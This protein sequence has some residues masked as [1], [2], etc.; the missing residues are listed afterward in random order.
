ML[1]DKTHNKSLHWIFTPLRSL[2]TSDFKRNTANIFF[3][4]CIIYC[5]FD[6][7]PILAVEYMLGIERRYIKMKRKILTFAVLILM[8]WL[9]NS[10]S[11]DNVQG[12]VL[13]QQNIPLPNITIELRY[14]ND[15][16]YSI[17]SSKGGIF[18]FDTVRGMV[19]IS[20]G[21][22]EDRSNIYVPTDESKILFNPS[23]ERSGKG[24]LKPKLSVIKVPKPLKGMYKTEDKTLIWNDDVLLDRS[25]G[26]MWY[27]TIYK[28]IP[29]PHAL[30][31]CEK[32]NVLG[33]AGWRIPNEGEIANTFGRNNIKTSP[34]FK[35]NLFDSRLPAPNEKAKG[36]W[37]ACW[38]QQPVNAATQ[39]VT[40][41]LDAGN[42]QIL[43]GLKVLAVRR[44]L[45][46]TLSPESKPEATLRSELVFAG[47]GEP[48]IQSL[49]LR[50]CNDGKKIFWLGGSMYFDEY[51]NFAN[52]RTVGTAF[53]VA[54][55][56]GKS[57][58]GECK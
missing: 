35:Y 2:K 44:F 37:L 19:T 58:L 52:K 7:M 49:L 26:L 48:E 39:K 9:I 47:S 11:Q 41:V 21:L 38:S 5:I 42:N 33:M 14:D 30:N 10:C 56:E 43:P 6:L 50:E 46:M 17:K 20:V 18:V 53:L 12:I 36:V 40:F 55:P 27:R 15:K 32:L 29:Y 34:I 25:T 8:F 24:V 57:I 51:G 54:V 45:S 4:Y 3:G 1:A 22:Q 13:D 16:V 28:E 31:Y 23:A